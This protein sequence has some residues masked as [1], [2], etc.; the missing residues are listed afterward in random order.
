MFILP[1]Y[2][3][4]VAPYLLT[5]HSLVLLLLQNK[6]QQMKAYIIQLHLVVMLDLSHSSENKLL[7]KTLSSVPYQT[8]TSKPINGIH[9][10]LV[11]LVM[12][13]QPETL[14]AGNTLHGLVKETS[15]LAL[16]CRNNLLHTYQMK[17]QKKQLLIIHAQMVSQVVTHTYGEQL[18]KLHQ[19][20]QQ[21]SLLKE[22]V[23]QPLLIRIT[24]Q[25]E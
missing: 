11:V 4:K 14:L 10:L 5:W 12:L 15:G 21:Q 6:M 22:I 25:P 18:I 23:M 8:L 1:L 3:L 9:M 13:H 24:K 19:Y 7:L 2:T 17:V 16:E 20:Q